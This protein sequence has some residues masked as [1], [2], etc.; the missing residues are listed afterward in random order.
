MLN[1]QR[2]V[3]LCVFLCVIRGNFA[4]EK[5]D[6]SVQKL[7]KDVQNAIHQ[8]LNAYEPSGASHE[9]ANKWILVIIKHMEFDQL[10]SAL[11]A[12]IASINDVTFEAELVSLA[13]G[14][15]LIIPTDEQEPEYVERAAA[16]AI[17]NMFLNLRTMEKV[18][19]ILANCSLQTTNT[20]LFN[21]TD[22]LKRKTHANKGAEYL[23][24]LFSHWLRSVIEVLESDPLLS[25]EFR[26]LRKD[27]EIILASTDAPAMA[28][29]IKMSIGAGV[30]TEEIKL[31]KRMVNSTL[32]RRTALNRLFLRYASKHMQLIEFK[33]ER[34]YFLLSR[35]LISL[36]T[37]HDADYTLNER[38]QK[39]VAEV[40]ESVDETEDMNTLRD[41]FFGR[42][43]K[44]VQEDAKLNERVAEIKS[45]LAIW[46]GFT[47]LRRL[48]A[49]I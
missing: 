9:K 28:T 33:S 37:H 27:A 46:V 26:K 47:E 13:D 21:N 11:I 24:N 29:E 35:A 30:W 1:F 23:R 20:L 3:K 41:K 39:T 22:T 32:F 44:M 18:D 14:F 19:N 25:A 43:E 15:H 16:I 8:I 36:A 38:Y 17:V 48:L 42:L 10:R 31:A 2:V 40:A 7:S 45:K 5:K 12:K 49:V 4:W 6:Y 34:K